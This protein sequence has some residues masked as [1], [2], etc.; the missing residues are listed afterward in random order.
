MKPAHAGA[1]IAAITLSA[2]LGA[3]V[4]ALAQEQGAE[5]KLRQ[6]MQQKQQQLDQI[7]KQQLALELLKK[8]QELEKQ[9]KTGMTVDLVS[10]PGGFGNPDPQITVEEKFRQL[11]EAG[12]FDKD[13]GFDPNKEQVTRQQL[14]A[15]IQGL[16]IDK[17]GKQDSFSDVDTNPDW[18]SDYV[19]AAK[20]RDAIVDPQSIFDVAMDYY[21][22]LVESMME[23][24]NG[25]KDNLSDMKEA[26]RQ[27]VQ[28]VVIDLPPGT[29]TDLQ[30]LVDDLLKAADDAG[31]AGDDWADYPFY[32]AG[33]NTADPL[34]ADFLDPSG[35]G[36][37]V[38]HGIVRGEAGNGMALAGTSQINVDFVG[39]NASL[40]GAFNFDS[41]DDVELGGF[42]SGG[43]I[44]LWANPG[45]FQGGTI[46]VD[47][48]FDADF[49]GPGA[50]EL[51]GDWSFD[52]TG[53]SA[54]G[55]ASGQF[56]TKR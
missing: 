42:Y 26:M 53:G 29:Q 14:N 5:E 15:I 46:D 36:S 48:N 51:A 38:Y 22:R 6:L 11:L 32:A 12:V 45:A 35:N 30:R 8:Q 52:V 23:A 17:P 13:G 7:K 40:D 20:L 39:G 24:M 43:A 54:P 25:G 50:E 49:Y 19:E 44:T 31:G 28:K 27:Q 10:A 33:S 9:Q 1:A 21:R 34:A 55:E 37:A 18:Y 4:P 2:M 3:V 41:G 56:A 47:S 16:L